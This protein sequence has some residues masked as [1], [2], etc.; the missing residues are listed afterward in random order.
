MSPQYFVTLHLYRLQT[1]FIW[2]MF[3][4]TNDYFGTTVPHETVHFTL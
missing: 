1:Y 3:K 4:T 2:D